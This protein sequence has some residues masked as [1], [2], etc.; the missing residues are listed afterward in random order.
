MVSI[1]ANRFWSP[2][3]MVVWAVWRYIFWHKKALRSQPVTSVAAKDWGKH[4]SPS[5]TRII[6]ELWRCFL[7][8]LFN[9]LTGNKGWQGSRYWTNCIGKMPRLF[10]PGA[11]CFGLGVYMLAPPGFARTRNLF[12]MGIFWQVVWPCKMMRSV[13]DSIDPHTSDQMPC[14]YVPFLP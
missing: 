2:V 8:I 12:S 4:P 14:N 6:L 9:F 13:L 7:R 11:N 5:S 10:I 3:L 1:R